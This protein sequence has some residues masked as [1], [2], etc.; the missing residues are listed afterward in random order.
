MYVYMYVYVYVLYI[1][2]CV[3]ARQCLS[4]LFAP[5]TQTHQMAS[6][7]GPLAN[8]ICSCT[9]CMSCIGLHDCIYLCVCAYLRVY[10]YLNDIV[11]DVLT[12]LLPHLCMRVCTRAGA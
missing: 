6:M 5:H 4:L 2:M 7:Q 3:C 9:I 1:C 8:N 12:C 11:C 10:V